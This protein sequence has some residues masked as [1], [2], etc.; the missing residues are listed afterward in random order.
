MNLSRIQALAALTSVSRCARLPA[1]RLDRSRVTQALVSDTRMRK[2]YTTGRVVVALATLT[3]LAALPAEAQAGE[4]RVSMATSAAGFSLVNVGYAA[5][6]GER[7]DVLVKLRERYAEGEVTDVVATVSDAAG[8]TPG[9]GCSRPAASDASTAICPLSISDSSGGRSLVRTTLDLLDGDDRAAVAGPFDERCSVSGGAG[10]D[11]LSAATECV[12][13]GGPGNDTLTGG[14]GK[15]LFLEGAADSGSDT[16]VGGAG[17]D[18]V[19]YQ[20]RPGGVR[21]DLAGDRDDGAPGERDRIGSDIENLTGGDGGDRLVGDGRDNDLSG[22]LGNDVL[23]GGDGE[24]RL[25]AWRGSTSTG[26][27]GDPSPPP[28]QNVSILLGGGGGAAERRSHNVL[29]GGGGDDSL[30]GDAGADRLDG[31]R[32]ADFLNGRG[33]RDVLDARDGGGHD[34]VVCGVGRDLA[35]L[36]GY[37]YPEYYGSVGRDRCERI[38]RSGAAVALPFMNVSTE[39]GTLG[40]EVGCPADG[41]RRCRGRVEVRGRGIA[42]RSRAFSIRSG[43]SRVLEIAVSRRVLGRLEQARTVRVTVSSFD[44]RGRLRR[45]S[46]RLPVSSP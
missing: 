2:R 18:L 12:F 19:S 1:S 37:D 39:T 26:S 36:D 13:D 10:D 31:G 33:G 38:R 11:S 45:R 6:P 42:F 7:N 24:D 4:A 34:F 41:P 15:D 5:R 22:D 17:P 3:V 44:R 46:E 29:S 35:L 21:A 43:A 25:Y 14:S 8:V 32:G 23:V 16:M 28:E 30:D 27:P 20:G 9:P 40:V